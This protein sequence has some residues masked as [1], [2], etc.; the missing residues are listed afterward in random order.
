[1]KKILLKSRGQIFFVFSAHKISLLLVY[2]FSHPI[3]SMKYEHFTTIA[4]A[5]LGTSSFHGSRSLLIWP[6]YFKFNQVQ[7]SCQICAIC[8]YQKSKKLIF[9]GSLLLF[10]CSCLKKFFRKMCFSGSLIT[11]SSVAQLLDIVNI[12][13]LYS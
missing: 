9:K 8:Q 6:L 1:M 3:P 4:K 7:I 13:V 2:S 12:I 10:F 11:N 5:N